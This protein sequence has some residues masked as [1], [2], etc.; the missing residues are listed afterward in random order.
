MV[1][2]FCVLVSL[3][4][5]DIS[6]IVIK[7]YSGVG[8]SRHRNH[9][10]YVL[11]RGKRGSF[12]CLLVPGFLLIPI[13]F[14]CAIMYNRYILGIYIYLFLCETIYTRD[15]HSSTTMLSCWVASRVRRLYHHSDRETINQ[16]MNRSGRNRVWQLLKRPTTPLEKPVVYYCSSTHSTS[17]I[18][19][20]NRYG[21]M[22]WA[23]DVD[24]FAFLCFFVHHSSLTGPGPDATIVSKAAEYI[25]VSAACVDV[26]DR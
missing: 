25:T 7:V 19:T 21:M 10:K 13:I 5:I 18:T 9:D 3:R 22:V 23:C 16:S 8:W 20:S 4:W 6:I 1:R 11:C 17:I 14:V 12:V 15:V 2:L 26:A 24:T